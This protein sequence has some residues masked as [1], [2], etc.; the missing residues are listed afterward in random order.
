MSMGDLAC[1]GADV[2]KNEKAWVKDG[3]NILLSA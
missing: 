3:E 1:I 2:N